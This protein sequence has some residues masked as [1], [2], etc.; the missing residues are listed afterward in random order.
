[1]PE[2]AIK[3]DNLS[4]HRSAG[5]RLRCQVGGALLV[6]CAPPLAHGVPRFTHRKPSCH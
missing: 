1:M 6:A 4:S 3:H 5:E 2:E